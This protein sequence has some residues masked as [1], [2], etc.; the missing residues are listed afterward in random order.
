M[1]R[2][3]R[4]VKENENAN[5]RASRTT[6]RT[7]APVASGTVTGVSTRA[8]SVTDVAAQG[9]RKREVLG[10]PAGKSGAA[11]KGKVA[12]DKG[13]GKEVAVGKGGKST[14]TTAARVPLRTVT[15]ART[16]RSNG[17]VED[18]SAR[19][20]AESMTIDPPSKTIPEVVIQVAPGRVRRATTSVQ[21]SKT[22]TAVSQKGVIQEST[23]QV[24][25]LEREFLEEPVTKKRRTSSEVGDE[26]HLEVVEEEEDVHPAEDVQC[27]VA[28]LADAEDVGWD[29]LDRDDD[30]DPLMVSEYAAEIYE[31]LMSCEVRFS[32]FF[33]V[34]RY[35]LIGCVENNDAQPQLRRY[36]ERNYLGNAR[37][38]R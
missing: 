20:D 32:I 36:A 37:R 9:K 11:T 4:S 27:Q 6:T 17:A 30:E 28:D 38:T 24:T 35:L 5:A 33:S 34:S 21:H 23:S 8:T 14:G 18:K 3:T 25:R 13:K 15:T 22:T 7:K 16:T 10:E 31:Y 29:D 2:A 26:A 12:E 1:T 19:P